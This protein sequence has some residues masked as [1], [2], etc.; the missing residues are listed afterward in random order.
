MELSNEVLDGLQI[1][2]DST[3]LPDS[4][5]A[6]TVTAVFHNLGTISDDSI[7]D[8][9]VE[10]KNSVDPAVDKLV[11]WS[12]CSLMLEAAKHNS[13]STSV[14]HVLEEQRFSSDRIKLIVDGYEKHKAS[15]RSSLS[16]TG[17]SPPQIVD[18]SWRLDYS[19][20]NNHLSKD[21]HAVYLINLK[22]EKDERLQDV[23][24]ACTQTQLQDLVYKL[25][26]AC[27]S[28]ERIGS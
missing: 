17:S 3:R 26:D 22:T 4:A 10:G 18:V 14:G 20:K 2:G 27:K 7:T 6:Q 5:F 1:V 16:R 9:C 19:I 28:L 24:L 11:H 12:L 23:Q 15:M 13:D 21:S 25:R 8:S